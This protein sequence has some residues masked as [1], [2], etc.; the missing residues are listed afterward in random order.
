MTTETITAPPLVTPVPI[1][2]TTGEAGEMLRLTSPT[3]IRDLIASGR[4]RTAVIGN[5][6]LVLGESV[7]ALLRESEQ[8]EYQPIRE[9]PRRRAARGKA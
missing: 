3:S 8:I 1:A 7:V 4:L 5:R 9:S 2:M 6:R